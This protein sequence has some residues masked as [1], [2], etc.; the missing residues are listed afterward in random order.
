[1]PL[2]N[3]WPDPWAVQ[4]TLPPN[5]LGIA[6]PAVAGQPSTTASTAAM[7]ILRMRKPSS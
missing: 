1:M 5:T 4:A 6:A 3:R 2:Q 7:S